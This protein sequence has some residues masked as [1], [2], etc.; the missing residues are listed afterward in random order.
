MR[1]LTTFVSIVLLSIPVLLFSQP[2]ENWLENSDPPLYP[3]IYL[4]TDR[5]VY[6]PGD[7]IWFKAYYLDGQTQK[8]FPGDYSLY[9]DLLDEHGRSIQTQVLL[10]EDGQSAGKIEIPDTILP[11]NYL[12]RAFTDI[13]RSIGE[14]A[15]FH[16]TLKVTSVESRMEQATPQD[17]GQPPDI[18]VAFL[19]EGGFMLAGQINC[20]AV[21]AVDTIGVGIPLHGEIIDGKGEVVTLFNTSYKGMGSFQFSPMIE[22]SYQ[23]RIKGYP[24]FEYTFDEIVKEGIKIEFSGESTDNLL[25][26]VTTNSESFLGKSFYFAILHRGRVLFH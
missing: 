1:A 26:N 24:D 15:F 25:L 21:K 22:E 4:H 14:D 20:V 9:T 11:G 8:L 23:V 3:K 7:S 10:M 13:Q 2:P 17:E 18:D 6:F 16:K 12:I 5:E 19:P